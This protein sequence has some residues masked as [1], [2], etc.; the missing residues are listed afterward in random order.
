MN[1]QQ[2]VLMKISQKI[3]VFDGLSIEDAQKLLVIG[4]MRDISEGE[5]IYRAGEPSTDMM[6]LIS[7][8]LKVVGAAGQDIVEISPGS[9]IGEMGMFT[10]LP[11]SA[12]IVAVT[13][14]IAL[15]LDRDR[16]HELLS[17]ELS[18]K[19]TILENVVA[20]LS[21]RLAEADR[22]LEEAAQAG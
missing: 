22:K 12:N 18:M 11:R 7:G 14:G 20:E 21:E 15:A 2:H 3:R 4:R 13:Q 9:S 6:V 1:R 8:K 16:F 19:A 10:G 5:Q 17:T